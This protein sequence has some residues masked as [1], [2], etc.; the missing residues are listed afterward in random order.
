MSNAPLSSYE[1]RDLLL[2]YIEQTRRVSIGKIC[3]RFQ[4]S[5]ATARRDLGALA[6][7]SKVRRVHGGAISVTQAPQELPVYQRMTELAENKRR[8]G[9][10][11]AA[12]LSDGE[13]VFLGSGTT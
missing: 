12:L 10:A 8:I 2:R 13:T 4:I 7:Q 5:E 11:A 3:E 1:R 6:E 9:I